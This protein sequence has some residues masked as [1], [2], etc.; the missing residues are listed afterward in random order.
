MRMASVGVSP[1]DDGV[2]RARSTS[3]FVG[4][5]LAVTAVMVVLALANPVSRDEGAFTGP[6]A[7]AVG[8]RPYVDFLYLQTPLQA[9]VSAPFARLF[10]GYGFIALRCAVGLMGAGILALVYAAQRGLAVDRRMAAACTALLAACYSFQF[11]CGV[12]RNDALSAV[13]ATGAIQLALVALR[14][15]L[16]PGPAW[17]AAGLLFGAAASAKI[18]Y[19]FPAAGAGLFLIAQTARGR[20]S[21][22]TLAAFV[23]GGLVGAL[24]CLIAW[25]QAPAAFIYSALTFNSATLIQWYRATHMAWVVSPPANLLVTVGILLVGPG[26]G[27]LWLAVAAAARRGWVGADEPAHILLLDILVVAG[28]IA[29]LLPTPSNFQY[30]LPMLPALFIRLG[31]EGRRL[32]AAPRAAERIGAGLMAFGTVVG[33]GYGMVMAWRGFTNPDVWPSADVTRQAHW[34]GSRLRAANATGFVTT[35]SPQVVLDSS[36]PLDPRFTTGVFVYRSAALLSEADLARFNSV[37]PQTLARALDR[38]PPAAIVVGGEGELDDA[39][40]NYAIRHGYRRE[41]SPF[42]R[43]ELDIPVS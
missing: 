43:F 8:V 1:T 40:R 10:P 19:A 37:G 20:I 29:A 4:A 38:S 7:V 26:L 27:A 18:S 25:R 6:A 28:L 31:V 42:G 16:R 39:L 23:L 30:V 13:L 32:L 41:M 14:G 11:G 2:D 17:A 21:P 33:C 3:L 22:R 9:L 5:W 12:V 15:R 36:Y 34:I 35:L 24:P